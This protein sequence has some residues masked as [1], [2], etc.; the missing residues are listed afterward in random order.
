MP[1][2]QMIFSSEVI[3]K[4]ISDLELQESD[5]TPKNLS[6]DIQV[7]YVANP[8]G[9]YRIFT[10]SGLV[11]TI[12]RPAPGKRWKVLHIQTVYTA[13]AMAGARTPILELEKNNSIFFSS[14][15]PDIVSA[16]TV[17]TAIYEPGVSSNSS[18][19]GGIAQGPAP[20]DVYDGF[21]IRIVDAANIDAADTVTGF[22]VVRELNVDY[23]F[24]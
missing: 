24:P 19:N 20:I 5:R 8:E 2:S 18:A 23:P 21:G 17:S 13:S 12:T 7:V 1:H 10:F 16:S 22:I 15:A 14:G 9:K 11:G 3:Q 4:I 6:N